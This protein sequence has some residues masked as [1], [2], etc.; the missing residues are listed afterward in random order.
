MGVVEHLGRG[1]DVGDHDGPAVASQAVLQDP[2]QLA[3]P[4]RDVGFLALRRKTKSRVDISPRNEANL[5]VWVH[6]EC[7]Q[8]SES[9][10]NMEPSRGLRRENTRNESLRRTNTESGKS[11]ACDTH[12]ANG[13]ETTTGRVFVAAC[14]V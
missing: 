13:D 9:Q 1:A 10:R 4:V 5:D 11:S 7:T 8:T 12:D 14:E 2:G 6:F 3:V